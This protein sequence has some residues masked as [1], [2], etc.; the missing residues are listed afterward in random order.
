MASFNHRTTDQP[1]PLE[2]FISPPQFT[3]W[4]QRLAL[5]LPFPKIYRLGVALFPQI[6]SGSSV[7]YA[8]LRIVASPTTRT[9]G[10]VVHFDSVS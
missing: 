9:T 8:L 1:R 4:D 7:H 3:Q 10:N 5:F 6:F 2:S